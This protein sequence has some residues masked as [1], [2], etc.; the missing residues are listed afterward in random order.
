MV[1]I[2]SAGKFLD[3]VH[4]IQMILYDVMCRNIERSVFISIYDVL[5]PQN[6]LCTNSSVIQS[7]AS[8]GKHFDVGCT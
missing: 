8:G 7:L 2:M 5:L 4:M 6:V 1:S 3:C